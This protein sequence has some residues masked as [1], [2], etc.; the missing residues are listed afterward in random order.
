M[1]LN[2]CKPTCFKLD[3]DPCIV[4]D[5]LDHFS[6]SPDHNADSKPGNWNLKTQRSDSVWLELQTQRSES[7]LVKCLTS[8]L[9]PPSRPLKSPRPDL[10]SPSFSLITSNTNSLA[11]W[12]LKEN[13][14]A[15]LLK[16]WN[17]RLEPQIV[18]ALYSVLWCNN[19]N[20][21]KLNGEN[22]FLKK[23]KMSWG[24]L[25]MSI[26]KIKSETLSLLKSPAEGFDG[27][28]RTGHSLCDVTHRAL[29]GCSSDYISD[30]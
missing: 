2:R 14:F 3:S 16:S 1:V 21:M 8:R 10:K 13:I 4:L 9:L 20:V 11:A 15:I 22:Y 18:P 17:P 30:F 29:K 23:K 19:S 24:S 12:S 25:C 26:K 28:K 6:I 7:C 5:L 27:M